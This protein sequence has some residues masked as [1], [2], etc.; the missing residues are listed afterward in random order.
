MAP[1][2]KSVWAILLALTCCSYSS[3]FSQSVLSAASTRGHAAR[4]ACGRQSGSVLGRTEP[5]SRP[6]ALRGGAGSLSATAGVGESTDETKGLKDRIANFY[7]QSSP[8]WE[9]IWGEHM[10]SPALHPIRLARMPTG[11]C[12]RVGGACPCKQ[13]GAAQMPTLIVMRLAGT[14]DTT[15]IWG[16]RRRATSRRKRTWL[17]GSS[18]LAR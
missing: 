3:A 8:L 4:L 6:D 17:T 7:D 2:V 11:N 18:T 13:A 12:G 9:D 1:C 14:W 10:S 15:A 16:T 5:G